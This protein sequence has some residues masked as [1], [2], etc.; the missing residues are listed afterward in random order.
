MGVRGQIYAGGKGVAAGYWKRPELTAERFIAN[1]FGAGRLYK[2]GD[3]ARFLPDGNIE[4]LGRVDHQ[5]KIR[6]FRIELEEIE[7]ALASHP[8]VREAVVVAR[9]DAPGE[10]RL[11]AYYTASSANG[12]ATGSAELAG[13]LAGK[14]ADYVGPAGYGREEGDPVTGEGK[15]VPKTR[16]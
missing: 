7:A 10:K 15:L 16:A 9:E 12:K 4:Y 5:V 3:L 13:A 11:V 8:G 14:H 2:T 1:R 6:G